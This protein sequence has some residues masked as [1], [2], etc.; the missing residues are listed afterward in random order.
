MITIAPPVSAGLILM[1]LLFASSFMAVFSVKIRFCF[2]FILVF[3]LPKSI[4]LILMNVSKFA[5]AWGGFQLEFFTQ[6]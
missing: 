6:F 2:R 5:E 1:S 3:S 4:S